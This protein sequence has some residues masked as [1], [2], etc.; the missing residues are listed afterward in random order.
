MFGANA[1]DGVK[2]LADLGVDRVVIPPLAFDPAGIGD[3]LR[4]YGDDVIAK[5]A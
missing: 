5:V 3:A 1:L 2:R 4:R